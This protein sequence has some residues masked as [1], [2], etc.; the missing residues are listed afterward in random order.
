[1]LSADQKLNE[2]GLSPTPL[3]FMALRE[4]VMTAW[5]RGVRERVDGS[6]DLLSSVLINT[7][8]AFYGHIAESLTANNPCTTPRSKTARR[9]R[10]AASGRA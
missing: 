7:L 5:E 6:H 8:P 2:T 9:R 4:E 10:M 1:M 3:S